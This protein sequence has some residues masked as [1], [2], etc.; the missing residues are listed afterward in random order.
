LFPFAFAP[1]R[2]TL[3]LWAMGAVV[4]LSSGC[5]QLGRKCSLFGCHRNV[6]QYDPNRVIVNAGYSETSW[7]PLAPTFESTGYVEHFA[8]DLQE[9]PLPVAR[10]DSRVTPRDDAGQAAAPMSESVQIPVHPQ[11]PEL[12]KPDSGRALHPVRQVSANTVEDAQ[13]LLDFIRS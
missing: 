10:E 4:L 3:Q 5:H 11:E 6:P 8:D 9:I 12:V 1:N 2:K 7:I 13:L